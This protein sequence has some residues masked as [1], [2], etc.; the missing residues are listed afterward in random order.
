[1][2][3]ICINFNVRLV[4]FDAVMELLPSAVVHKQVKYT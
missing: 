3:H 4:T 2:A 1:M